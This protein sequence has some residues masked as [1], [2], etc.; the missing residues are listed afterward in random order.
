MAPL[1]KGI[2]AVILPNQMMQGAGRED[3]I[4]YATFPEHLAMWMMC[5]AGIDRASECTTGGGRPGLVIELI[6]NSDSTGGV[7][8]IPRL[9]TLDG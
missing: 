3:T 9:E 2:P 5:P 7:L 6:R 4:P 1:T 8:S